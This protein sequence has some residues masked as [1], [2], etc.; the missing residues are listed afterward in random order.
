MFL[1]C[2]LCIYFVSENIKKT[3]L[4]EC[5]LESAM[6]SIGL[7]TLIFGGAPAVQRLID[8]GAYITWTEEN[9]LEMVAEFNR[10][11]G[12]ETSQNN[13]IATKKACCLLSVSEFCVL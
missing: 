10:Q 3:C 8:S 5:L 12:G 13:S 11:V 4:R 6:H 9:G 2:V 7:A 1:S